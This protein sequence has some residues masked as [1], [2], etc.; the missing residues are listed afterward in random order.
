MSQCDYKIN[1]FC[2]TEEVPTRLQ[3]VDF[4][5]LHSIRVKHTCQAS[6]PF[7]LASSVEH[8]HLVVVNCYHV[9]R[10]QGL[11]TS[12]TSVALAFVETSLAQ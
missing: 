12:D 6:L 3:N 5:G 1:R 8:L 10:L 4:S 7:R 11:E 9:V 2:C